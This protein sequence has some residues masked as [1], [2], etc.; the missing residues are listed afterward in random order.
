MRAP[1]IL[2]PQ[3]AAT[4]SS[5]SATGDYAPTLTLAYSLVGNLSGIKV[6]SGVS[7]L[8]PGQL[9]RALES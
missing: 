5:L 9:D 4:V 6:R 8:S 2:T 7:D 1:S 3:L